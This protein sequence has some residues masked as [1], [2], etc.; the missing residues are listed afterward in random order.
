MQTSRQPS[1]RRLELDEQTMLSDDKLLFKLRHCC[2]PAWRATR[3]T[4]QTQTFWRAYAGLWLV[5]IWFALYGTGYIH[6][7]EHMQNGEVTAG[8]CFSI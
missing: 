3:M 8:T 4:P 1:I 6:P 5:R 7:D 2:V